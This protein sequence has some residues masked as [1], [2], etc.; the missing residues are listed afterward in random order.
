MSCVI[1][2]VIRRLLVISDIPRH[3]VTSL[4]GISGIWHPSARQTNPSVEGNISLVDSITSG[5]SE[6]SSFPYSPPF[7]NPRPLAEQAAP[8]NR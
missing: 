4:I 8:R 7:P 3:L 2:W 5:R 1:W 6:R